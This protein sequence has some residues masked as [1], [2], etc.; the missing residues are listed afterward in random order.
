MSGCCGSPW[1]ADRP[2]SGRFLA[3]AGVS[4]PGGCLWGT[5]ARFP[6]TLLGVGGVLVENDFLHSTGRVTPDGEL[7]QVV[8]VPLLGGPP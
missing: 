6:V 4:G 1:A 3:L 2:T 7:V 5:A 8:E